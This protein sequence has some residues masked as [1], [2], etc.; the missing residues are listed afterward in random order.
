[1]AV[2]IQKCMSLISLNPGT[3]TFQVESYIYAKDFGECPWKAY[4]LEGLLLGRLTAWKAYCLACGSS[5]L[6][7]GSPCSTLCWIM[8]CDFCELHD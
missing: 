3:E 2:F 5:V 4:C 7:V 1:M 8:N 6:P